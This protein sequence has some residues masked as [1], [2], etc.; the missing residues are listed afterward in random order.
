MANNYKDI[1]VPALGQL[2]TDDDLWTLPE[3]QSRYRLN[4]SIDDDGNKQILTNSLGN[5]KVTYTLP[6]TGDSSI[7]GFVEDVENKHGIY[8]LYNSS[9]NH[10]ILRYR[11]E[12]NDIQNI[13]DE[14]DYDL[15]FSNVMIHADV[16]GI[17]D[18]KILTWTDGVNPPRQ[19]NIE[20]AVAGS[21]TSITDDTVSVIKK[22]PLAEGNY[23][24]LTYTDD[25]SI[26]YNYLR[27]DLFQFAIRFKYTD[28]SYSV[29]SELLT[30]IPLGEN[31]TPETSSIDNTKNNN[32]NITV[33][34]IDGLVEYV[35]IVYRKL[36]V[37]GA[38]GDF[39]LFKTVS[40]WTSGTFTVGFKNDTAN[41]SIDNDLVLKQYDYVP[42]LAKTQESI[43]GNRIVYGGITEGYDVPDISVS[44]SEVTSTISDDIDQDADTIADT[45]SGSIT[46]VWNDDAYYNYYLFNGVS[47][48]PLEYQFSSNFA[49]STALWNKIASDFNAVS[50]VTASH[51]GSG[52]INVTNNTGSGI[53][54]AYAAIGVT[55]GYETFKQGHEVKLGLLYEDDYNRSSFVATSEDSVVF[56]DTLAS[57]SSSDGSYR[58]SI[59]YE[60]SHQAPSWATRWSWCMSTTDVPLFFR[61][62]VFEVI[63]DANGFM[64]ISL[65]ESYTISG[66][67]K[68]TSSLLPYNFTPQ[69]GDRLIYLGTVDG[70]VFTKKTPHTEVQII[71]YDS[72]NNTI[73]I[74][75]I[76]GINTAISS[77]PVDIIEIYRPSKTSD[78]NTFYYQFGEVGTISNRNHLRPQSQKDLETTFSIS[79]ASD[80]SYPSTPAKSVIDFGNCFVF[81]SFATFDE[82]ILFGADFY[83]DYMFTQSLSAYM[84]KDY[85]C[86]TSGKPYISNDSI[87]QTTS[88]SIR[89][90]GVL[91]TQS[92]INNLFTFDSDDIKYLNEEFSDLYLLKQVGQTLKCYQEAKVS[93]FGL[94]ISSYVDANG[95][96]TTYTTQNIIDDIRLPIERY[97]TIYPKSYVLNDRNGYFFDVNQGVVVRD[98]PNGFIAISDYKMR[99]YFRN[100]AKT[101]KENGVENYEVIGGYD[102]INEMYIITLIDINKPKTNSETLGFHEPTNRWISFYSYIPEF[103]GGIG[104]TEFMSFKDGELWLHNS[105][106]ANRNNFYA[107]AYD[108]NVWIVSNKDSNVLKIF[109]SIEL[110]AISAWDAPDN[111]SIIIEP[112][113][114]Y[115][116]GMASRFKEGRYRNREGVFEGALMRDGKNGGTSVTD[117]NLMNGRPLRGREITIKFENSDTTETRLFYI[118]VNGQISK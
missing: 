23:F 81:R 6:A 99:T 79:G 54:I 41:I 15:N 13:I 47:F 59:Q 100:W 46:V 18:D 92:G 50:G 43:N 1:I 22:T 77:S 117:D 104:G 94:G 10:R 115:P 37:D 62:P 30:A 118:G 28:K 14:G 48:D 82:S 7:I 40:E 97:G 17:G 3:H 36:N 9:G 31:L 91:N 110:G 113:S 60:I 78:T 76:D 58:S 87:G 44:L 2:N 39:F 98:S 106:T 74:P 52:V 11:S 45:A 67:S 38:T 112:T 102:Y 34:N 27:G 19:I 65:D 35:D 12:Q 116:N 85:R 49:S 114:K 33:N 101:M 63:D 56:I 73:K 4:V 25:T 32:I 42:Q 70:S 21:Y 84:F 68:L 80:Q 69:A 111:D 24:S 93:S 107:T 66:I 88:S 8:F 86:F 55:T 96:V 71:D 109:N 95:N 89:W 29:F 51:A 72:V 57:S 20:D 16:I 90:G 61:R 105:I 108:S 83:S 75:Y 53:A 103:Y 5:T 26:T 64:V